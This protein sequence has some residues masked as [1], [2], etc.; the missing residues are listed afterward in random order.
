MNKKEYL[1]Y[2]S[3]NI[4]IY[5]RI[6]NYNLSMSDRIS[7]EREIIKDWKISVKNVNKLIDD[8]DKDLLDG[9]IEYGIL[10]VC[11]INFDESK[12]IVVDGKDFKIDSDMKLIGIKNNIVMLK[13]C[14]GMIF[15]KINI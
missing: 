13:Y 9:L 12:F 6:E 7:I 15:I 10:E 5:E 2:V 4:D 8:L 1:E 14:D 3:E 11:E